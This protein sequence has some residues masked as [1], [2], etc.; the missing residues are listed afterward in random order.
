MPKKQKD[1]RYR[2]K[3][4]PAP[5]EK[6]V[7]I[8]ARTLRELND[9]KQHVLA[10]YRDG[11][12]PRDVTFHGLVTEWFEVVK[13]PRIRSRSTLHSYENII[14]THI[15]PFFPPQQLLRAVRRADLQRCLDACAGMSGSISTLV[16]SVLVHAVRYALAENLLEADISAALML[17]QASVPRAKAAFTPEEEE[18]LLRTAAASPD[19]LMIYLLYYL[20]CRR[21][22]MLG[23]QW[24]DFDWRA[25][26]VHIQRSVD[27]NTGKSSVSAVSATKTSAGDRWVPVP[28]DLAAILAP[29]RSRPQDLLVSD[30]GAPLTSNKFRT[31]WAHLMHA[32]GFLRLSPRYEAR[33]AAS[34]SAGKPCKAPNLSYDYDAEI[35]P[36]AFRHN[37][38]TCCVSA[39]IPPE[40]TMRIVGHRDYATTVNIYT[41]LQSEQTR[42]AAVSLAGVLRSAG[43]RE[44][45][46]PA[47]D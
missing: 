12:R 26:M 29:L 2:A 24:G 23:L 47:Q 31:R 35:T 39:G 34:R 32:A 22:E 30:Q 4:T 43:C 20:G 16:R 9:K 15:L 38:I 3:I 46:A 11:L 10:R 36:H 19:G 8:S 45:A 37:Y 5:G 40:I 44:V 21:G 7:Y 25:R 41:H 28:D 18:R 14:H 42:R 33:R 13:R 6:P 1:G 17:P 27:F